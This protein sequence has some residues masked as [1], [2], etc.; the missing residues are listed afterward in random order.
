MWVVNTTSGRP[1]NAATLNRSGAASCSVTSQPSPRRYSVRNSPTAFS[2]SV[3]DSIS[4]RRR[5]SSKGCT[6]SSYLRLGARAGVV[7]LEPQALG[8]ILAR[9]PR[10][11]V[12]LPLDQ[13]L[14]VAVRA[15]RT[16]PAEPRLEHHAGQGEEHREEH[17]RLVGDDPDR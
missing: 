16:P 8:G 6:A 2:W 4:I 12:H 11:D 15:G 1:R 13:W 10:E 5:V 9:D 7:D 14:Q 17:H 3:M